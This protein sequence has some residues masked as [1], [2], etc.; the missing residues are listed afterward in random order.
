MDGFKTDNVY[1]HGGDSLAKGPQVFSFSHG[2]SP[3][4]QRGAEHGAYNRLEPVSSL[5]S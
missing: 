2:P 4:T 5:S 3:R 1:F